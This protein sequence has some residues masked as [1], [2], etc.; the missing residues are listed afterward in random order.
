MRKSTLYTFG[1]AILAFTFGFGTLNCSAQTNLPTFQGGPWAAPSP[2]LPAFPG[3]AG[4]NYWFQNLANNTPTGMNCGDASG[5]EAALNAVGQ[6]VGI[7]FNGQAS[8]V[9]YYANYISDPTNALVVEESPDGSAWTVL[10]NPGALSP[11]PTC[12]QYTTPTPQPNTR[13]IRFRC[14]AH[15]TGGAARVDAINVPA[16]PTINFSTT[17]SGGCTPLVVTMHNQ[18]SDPNAYTYTWNFGDNTPV[19]TNINP[20]TFTH[21]YTTPGNYS[22]YLEVY[23][24][25]GGYVGNSYGNSGNIQINGASIYTNIQDSV[26]PNEIINFN[27]DNNVNSW[28]WNFGDGATSTQ[29]GV[30]HT[31]TTAATYTVSLT[32]STSNCGVSTAKKIIHVKNTLVPDA[33]FW[34]DPWQNICPTQPVNFHTNSAKTY[35]WNFGDGSPVSHQSDPIHSYSTSGTPSVTLTLVNGCNNSA[36]ATQTIAITPNQ[37]FP[38]GMGAYCNNDPACPGQQVNEYFYSNNIIYPKYV[39]NFGDGSPK[40]SSSSSVNHTFA[41][42]SNYTVTVKVRNFCGK[43]STFSN[44]THIRSYAPFPN[45]PWFNVNG[46]SPS[47]PNSN[48]NFNAPCCYPSYLWDFGDGTP[49]QTSSNN[50]TNHTYGSTIKTYT[51]SVKIH[52]YCGNDSTIFCQVQITNSVHFQN[53]NLSLNINSPACPNSNINFNVNGNGYPTYLWNFGDGSPVQT[54]S[55]NGTNHTYAGVGTYTASVKITNNCGIDTTLLGTVQ[56]NSNVSFPNQSWFNL[57]G[58]PD[59]A[60]PGD[61]VGFGGPNGYSTYQWNFGDGSPVQTN[62]YS[63]FQHIYNTLNT[64][65]VSLKITNT[66]NKDTT[67]YMVEHVVNNAGFQNLNFN[68]YPSTACPNEHVSFSTSSGYARYVWNFGDGSPKDTTYNEYVNHSYT[69]AATYTATVTIRNHC[70]KDTTLSQTVTISNTTQIPSGMNISVN[71]SPACPG[72]SVSF[73]IQS[74]FPYY[75]WDFGDGRIDSTSNSYYAQH[76]YSASATYTVSVKVKNYCGFSSTI[77]S[78]VVINNSVKFQNSNLV[79]NLNPNPVCPG[80]GV[81]MYVQSNNG[82]NSYASYVWH[83]GDGSV[84]D[85]I[86][87]S[88]VNHTYTATGTYTVSVKI[89]NFCDMD[90]TIYGAVQVKSN[91]GFTSQINLYIP[92]SACPN[93]AVGFSASNGYASYDWNFGDGHTASGSYYANHTYTATNTYTISV[94]I[95]NQCNKDTTLYNTIVI[96]NNGSFPNWMNI[97]VSPSIACP[98]G[99]IQFQM[100]PQGF[101][102]YFW[103]FG[104]GDTITTHA[105]RVQH[106]YTTTGVYTMSCKVT[107]GCGK[108]QTIYQTVQISGNAPV[109]PV[110]ITAPNNPACIGDAVVFMVSGGQSTFT[111][112]WNFGDGVKDTTIGGSPS[113]TYTATGSYTVTLTATN[114]CGNNTTASITVNISINAYPVLT[115]PGGGKD[116]GKL[117]GVPGSNGGDAGCVGDIISFYFMGYNPNN[118]WNFG[119]TTTGVAT[120]QMLVYGG[121]GSSFPVTFIKHAYAHY[122]PKTVKLTLTNHCGNSTTDS[123]HINIGG[124][125]LVNGSLN[126]S[127]PPYTTCSSIDFVAFGGATY[128]FDFGDGNILNTSSPTASHIYATQGNYVVSV[129]VTNG[130]GNSASYTIPVNVSGVGGPTINISSSANPTCLGNDGH[131]TVSVTTGQAP[132]SYLWDNGQTTSTATGLSAGTFVATVTD[133]IGCPNSVP[134]TLSNPAPI[135]LASSTTQANCG[136]SNGTATIGVTSG[137]NSPYHYLWSSGSTS[138]TATGLSYGSYAVTVTDVNGCTA[139]KHISISEL[140]TATVSVNTITNASCNGGSNGVIDIN[141]SG[142]NPPFVYAW[143]NGATTQDAS[144]LAAGTYSVLVTDNGSC[145][146]T[147]IASVSQPPTIAA[148]TSVVTAPTCGNFDGKATANVSGGTS[149]Y[150]YLWSNSSSQTTQTATGLGAGTRTVTVTD[151]KGCST[152]AISSLSNS[153]SPQIG[154]TVNNVTCNGAGNGSIVLNVTGGN[155]NYLY[156]WSS[157]VLVGQGTDNATS[158]SPGSY[159]VTVEDAAHCFSFNSYNITEPAVLTTSVSN[160][161][162]TCGNTDGTATALASGGNIPYSYLWTGGQTTQTAVGLALGSRTVTVTDSKGCTTSATTTLTATTISTPVC[163]VSVD[164]LTS[165]RNIIV[166]N[167]PVVTNIDSFRVYREISSAY[168]H[169]ANV[170]YSALSEYV[171]ITNG[172]NPNITSYKYKISAVDHCG[173]VSALSSYHQTI[174]LSVSAATPCGFNLSW[175]DYVGMPITQYRIM[176]DSAH[177]GWKAMDSV[178]Y[179]NTAWTDISCYPANDS[180][181]YMLEID[182]GSGC[183]ASLKNDPQPMTIS[184]NSSRSNVYRVGQNPTNVIITNADMIALV[185]PNPNSGFFTID[186]KNNLT[187]SAVINVFNMIGEKVYSTIQQTQSA[188]LSLN[189]SKQPQG[190]YY[191]QISTAKQ[192]IT[193]KIVIE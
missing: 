150:T 85:S 47:C 88:S 141:V 92:S 99:L 32:E 160:T 71:S 79:L 54:T 164:T 125:L 10:H 83:Y 41:T 110:S 116:G 156:T 100:N 177:T 119:D 42:P 59:P 108:S 3:N 2:S 50:Y 80:G 48:V 19:V 93:D 27:G 126:I 29:S 90:T 63:G 57:N 154:A 120:Q 135:V 25:S 64:Y 56:I 149:P 184:L 12:T 178:S 60:C 9:S 14:T 140:N 189:L 33:S 171:D 147:Y 103:T 77:Y 162:A 94:K 180:I 163:I 183:T 165:S 11:D 87:S 97:N 104:D 28:S 139:S 148:T 8:S 127:P 13:Y 179:G 124:S 52:S 151:S 66:C 73:D 105:E 152:H 166:W 67:L 45:Q 134:V 112:A 111:Y 23:N 34:F 6:Y 49:Q 176:R 137:G 36:S 82:G 17:Y 98:G 144:N 96:D 145:K 107:N 191:L 16:A 114:G 131:A 113:H 161:G 181:F 4:S 186:L 26:C 37:G 44:V 72:S 193:K 190:V 187:G 38:S 133:N 91:V 173:G 157:N 106:S 69:A 24:S 121:D 168:T 1:I 30:Q 159:I 142:G 58:G 122:G 155:G 95:T 21:T 76:S 128:L 78:T 55:N 146:A 185:Y 39:W 143:S 51:V 153:N 65:T 170:A 46:T 117:W 53:S 123:T 68:T 130:C 101:A 62:N 192:T 158:L 102:S 70:N 167:K 43:D 40:D 84:K 5:G 7:Y 136:V 109:S 75:T 182:N 188:K 129:L 115:M 35:T 22:V 169:I 172:V 175:N 81:N 89:R 86:T 61:N 138:T 174:H 20:N 74:G 132:Y 31:Y 18:T 118:L 15:G